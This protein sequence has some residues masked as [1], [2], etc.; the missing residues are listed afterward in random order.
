MK[1]IILW[2]TW[3]R[4][5]RLVLL[6]HWLRLGRL[7]L[8]TVIW[9]AFCWGIT[10]Y[11][12]HYVDD[13]GAVLIGNLLLRAYIIVFPLYLFADRLFNPANAIKF[14]FKYMAAVIVGA[15]F[16]IAAII[17]YFY[18]IQHVGSLHILQARQ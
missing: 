6:L 3:L 17:F 13:N 7:L 16:L 2:L 18:V 9:G 8:F 14:I 11:Y 12:W 4:L 5:E 10:A 15:P 1:K